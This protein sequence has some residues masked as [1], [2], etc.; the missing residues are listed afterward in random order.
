LLAGF[1]VADITPPLGVHLAG[2]FNARPAAEVHDPLTA[3]AMVLDDGNTTVALVGTDLVGMPAKLVA[4]SRALV[5]TQTG[6]PEDAV[7]IWA[8]HTHAGPELGDLKWYPNDPQ[9]NRMLPK[10]VAG[11]VAGA[12]SR[13]HETSGRIAVGAERRIS[14]NR[15]YR[16]TGGGVATN[17]GVGNPGATACDG[18]IDPDVGVLL[19]DQDGRRRAALVNFA[20]HLDVLGSGNYQYS[21]DY[22]Y[23]LRQMLGDVYGADFVTLFG[24]GPCGNLNHINVFAGKH[25]GGYDHARM[26]GRTLAGEV[27]KMDFVAEPIELAPLWHR[28]ESVELPLRRF[29]DDEIAGFRKVL[30]ETEETRDQM[31]S[32]NFARGRAQRAIKLVE[33][34]VT[35]EDV[36]VQVLG[37]GEL[38]IV[39]IPGEYFVEFGLQIKAKSPAKATYVIELANGSIGYIPTAEALE[40]GAYEASSARFVPD[41]GQRL[42]DAALGMLAGAT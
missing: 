27:M 15:N 38:A 41:A 17:P 5:A 28:S 32:A 10:L 42:A 24:N 6:I 39:G 18:P 30:A 33:S 34:G 22:P 3:Y 2:H 12:H 21:A 14:F 4:E 35:S 8:T 37:L 40:Q 7:M 36:E 1:Q 23:Y 31:S 11:C 16:M 25:Q 20:C 29:T 13:M 9:F 19:L 26:M